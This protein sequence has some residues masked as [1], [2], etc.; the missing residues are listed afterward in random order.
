MACGRSGTSAL[1][2]A[3]GQHPGLSYLRDPTHLWAAID[4]AL[5]LTNLHARGT[6]RLWFED[7]ANERERLLFARTF[8][9]DCREGARL[10]EKTPHN[11][12]RARWIRSLAPS[13]RFLHIHRDGADVASSIERIADSPPTYRILGRPAH[14][15]WW[16]EQRVKWDVIASE[17]HD[18]P[19]V[20]DP[21]P[22]TREIDRGAFEWLLSELEADR[23]REELADRWLTISYHDLTH[24]PEETL[25][26][27]AQLAELEADGAWLETAASGLTSRP[28]ASRQ[29]ALHPTLV[30]PFNERQ[31]A[32]GYTSIATARQAPL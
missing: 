9:P 8:A 25:T 31:Q 16:G 3:L 29:I 1:G 32:L 15:Q 12:F 7:D 26:R 21:R 5:D 13:A 6:P 14:H 2:H 24:Q 30:E 28:S 22:L 23:L 18:R 19:G 4:P 20:P 10:L 11:I 27:I 17:A